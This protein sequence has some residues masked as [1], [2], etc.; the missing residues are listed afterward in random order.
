MMAAR[1]KAN[2][3]PVSPQ[4]LLPIIWP[5]GHRRHLNIADD[6]PPARSAA[7]RSRIRWTPADRVVCCPKPLRQPARIQG[8]WEDDRQGT[9]L[10]ARPATGSAACARRATGTKAKTPGRLWSGRTASTNCLGENWGQLPEGCVCREGTAV[11]VDFRDLVYFLNRG[12]CPVI[13]FDT[14]ARCRAPGAT[15]CLP[16]PTALPSRPTTRPSAWTTATE[17]SGSY[18]GLPV[19]NEEPRCNTR[20]TSASISPEETGCLAVNRQVSQPNW[21]MANHSAKVRVLDLVE[22]GYRYALPSFPGALL[23]HQ[24]KHR[25]DSLV[26]QMDTS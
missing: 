8:G 4:W 25:V 18:S 15:G 19:T 13:V 20:N 6:R 23:P 3:K 22:F 12:T 17:Q 21:R 24:Q 10:G 11:A 7:G 26:H 5:T 1:C 14:T 2:Q 16:T 9:G